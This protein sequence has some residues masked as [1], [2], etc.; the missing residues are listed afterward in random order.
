MNGHPVTAGWL[1][2]ECLEFVEYYEGEKEANEGNKEKDATDKIHSINKSKFFKIHTSCIV[3][4]SSK[5][6]LCKKYLIMTC[7]QAKNGLQSQSG[8]QRLSWTNID[9]LGLS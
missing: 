4:P 1:I 8:L 2:S 7:K 6:N 5:T 9:Y 3:R